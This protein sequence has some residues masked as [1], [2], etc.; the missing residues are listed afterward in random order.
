MRSWEAWGN[1]RRQVAESEGAFA[2]PMFLLLMFLPLAE[3]LVMILVYQAVAERWGTGDGLLFTFGMIF[4]T[5][6][7]GAW[8]ARRQGL[9]ALR[10]LETSLRRGESPGPALVDAALIVIG[11]TLLILPGYLTDLLGVGLLAPW[12]R[13]LF[14]R[15]LLRGLRARV[16]RGETTFVRL[17]HPSSNEGPSPNAKDIVIDVTPIEEERDDGAQPFQSDGT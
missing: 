9:R 6:I 10:A 16:V 4:L 12:T 8:V 17:G 1:D 14:R 13:W 7:V 3:L 5:A 15:T 2:L 11:G